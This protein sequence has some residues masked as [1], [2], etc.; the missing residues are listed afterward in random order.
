MGHV[1]GAVF[2]SVNNDPKRFLDEMYKMIECDI[3]INFDSEHF[4]LMNYKEN[5]NNVLFFNIND[6]LTP[7]ELLIMIRDLAKHGRMKDNIK[8]KKFLI[9][10]REYDGD[11]LLEDKENTLR[12]EAF[13][14]MH[15]F[16][17]NPNDI[18]VFLVKKLIELK[19]KLPKLDSQ[20][21][22]IR[23]KIQLYRVETILKAIEAN[24]IPEC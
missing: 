8:N 24:T 11:V 6:P 15:Q 17:T 5:G 4:Y 10:F 1:V 7:T 14:T 9:H 3:G 18:R 13:M 21:D 19:N 23:Y 2:A 12:V 16:F 20:D 22:T